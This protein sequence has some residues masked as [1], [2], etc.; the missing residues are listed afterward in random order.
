TGAG[1][2][3]GPEEKLSRRVTGASPARPRRV[4]PVEHGDRDAVE[5]FV[6]RLCDEDIGDLELRIAGHPGRDLLAQLLAIRDHRRG[7]HSQPV[8][9]Y[10]PPQRY[11]PGC[12]ALVRGHAGRPYHERIFSYET[13]VHEEPR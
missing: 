12:I 3:A 1:S 8:E 11:L 6:R 2:V 7:E 13:S 4:L 9:L 10:I 5:C